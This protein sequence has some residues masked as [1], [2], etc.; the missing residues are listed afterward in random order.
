V[1]TVVFAPDSFKGSLPAAAV[2]SVLAEGWQS[3]W[4]SDRVILLPQAD[5]GEGTL[6]TVATALPDAV[7]R[8][9]GP[10]TGP[11]GRPVAG[12]WLQLA[13]GTAIVELAS[14]SGLPL[15]QR[16]DAL[17]ATSRGLGEVIRA[18]LASGATSLVIGLGGSAST[19]AGT[20]A[21]A[22]LGLRMS[23]AEGKPLADGGG[24]LAHLAAVDTAG[25]LP[26]P[27]GGVVLLTDVSAPLTGASGAAAVFGPQKGAT[28]EQ[29]RLLDSALSGLA[30]LAGG[31]PD[32]PGAGAAGGAAFGFATFWGG[33]I[34]PGADYLARLSGLDDALDDADV[35]ITGE[36]RFDDQ[37][38]TG[39]LVGTLL[40]RA[41]DRGVVAGVVAGQV[42]T[43]S[44][45]W[46]TSL[47]ELSGS[48]AAALDDPAR[49][50]REAGARAA[51]E[52]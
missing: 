18:A 7:R 24:A 27:A 52:L 38:L 16:L 31:A 29:V 13:N 35:L 21:L 1:R 20:G 32:A 40:Q 43:S 5:G 3:V 50:L 39:K 48:V 6:D 15:M 34:L 45:V 8:G 37:S 17:G 46:T 44:S 33:S 14:V 25:L 26:P 47:A 23:D 30:S 22:A 10:V 9:A 2:A 51:R 36:G 28:P 11:D 42:T 19:D 49:W 12:G 41:S 4:P